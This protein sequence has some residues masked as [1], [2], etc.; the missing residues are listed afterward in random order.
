[1]DPEVKRYFQKILSSFCMGL[2]WM[3]SIAT[4]GL[5]FKLALVGKTWFWY[6]GLFYAYSLLTLALLLRYYYRM[7]RDADFEHLH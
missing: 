3:F 1:M 7:W 5:Y 6:N 4:A 2:L